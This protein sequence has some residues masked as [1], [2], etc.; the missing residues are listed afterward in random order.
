MTGEL[1]ISM[2]K[3]QDQ[4]GDVFGQKIQDQGKVL[5]ETE[6]VLQGGQKIERH[7]PLFAGAIL[8]VRIF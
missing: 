2:Q 7:R 4:V 1:K 8:S 3:H 5:K 6:D